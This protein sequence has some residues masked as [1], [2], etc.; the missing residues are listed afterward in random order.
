MTMRT[1]GAD[2]TIRPS[3][4]GEYLE[5]T[6]P[7]ITLLVLITTAVGFYMNSTGGIDGLLLLH[8]IVGVG[9]VAGG[10][11]ALNQYQE[12]HQDARMH[13]TR[14]RPLPEGR[15]TEFDALVFSWSISVAGIVYLLLFTNLVTGVL[16]AITLTLYVFLYTPLKSRT[17]LAILVGA[18]PGAAPPILGWT[19]A[20][21]AVDGMAIVLFSIVF[22]WQM[23]HFLAIAWLYDEDYLR[24][25]FQKLTIRNTGAESAS[26][27]IIFFCC[28][29]I[30]ISIL[31]TSFGVT[32]NIYMFGALMAGV[33]YLGYGLA[34]ALVR[35]DVA[36]RR[37]L[38]ASVL[39][40]PAVFL[41]MVID[42]AI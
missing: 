42:K 30:P 32:G 14:E 12:R 26:L 18:V 7:R 31:P 4:L 15:I 23:P 3:R 16:A 35:S 41:L 27:Q 21:G 5:L 36:A 25:G 24:G 40:L 38:K 28:A 37:L 11:S 2:A 17:A 33:V 13:R 9:L 1:M 8:P 6:K 20:G 19:S 34:V 39:Y 10:A 22:L 29:L